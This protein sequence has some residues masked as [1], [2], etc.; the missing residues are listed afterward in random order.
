MTTPAGWYPDPDQPAS[1]RYWDGQQ[2]TEHTVPGA[3]GAVMGSYGRSEKDVTRAVAAVL[4]R[5]SRTN[6]DV[7]QRS[8]CSG[9]E[10][11]CAL[12]MDADAF[13]EHLARA[14]V[15]EVLFPELDSF[16]AQTHLAA[17]TLEL[18]GQLGSPAVQDAA[19][20]MG[21]LGPP[22]M[23]HT[24]PKDGGVLRWWKLLL[25]AGFAFVVVGML[26]LNQLM[27]AF[28]S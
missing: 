18:I 2:W 8:R 5:H 10:V 16:A 15:E 1:R 20:R 23:Q 19:Q 25:W 9:G 26:V 6:P 11:R 4:W 17:Q 13:N 3:A 22:L 27:D 7:A 21:K 24:K 14:V 12:P 28:S